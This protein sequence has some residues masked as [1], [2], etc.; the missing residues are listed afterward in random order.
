MKPITI[1]GGGLAGLTL[2]ILLRRENVPVAAIEAGKYPR[3]RV[4]GEFISGRGL[5]IFRGL[6]L[7][8]GKGIEASTCSFHLKNR[9]PVKLKLDPSALCISR[10]ELDALL[11]EEFER[12]G[13]ILKLGERANF[14]ADR[15]GVVRA[16]G[17][18]RS[19]NA[20]GHL[21][22]LK[23]HAI[24]AGL[25]SDL[26][27]H[28]GAGNYVGVC[29]LG[30]QRANVCGLFYSREPMRSLNE[31]WKTILASS[32]WSS[33]VESVT[34]DEAS[35]SS[36][37]GLT[38]SRHAPESRF[39]IGDAAAMIPPLTGNGMSMAFESAALA[40][41]WLLEFSAGR[42]SWTKCL[43]GHTAAWRKAF[44][45]RLRWAGFV[46]PVLFS[47]AGQEFL[48][49]CTRLFPTLPTFFFARTR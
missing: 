9:R 5:G 24:G 22:G 2:G 29:K 46:Q 26:E 33:A 28:F 44:S 20:A 35:F 34:W 41:K 13:G 6:G 8:G 11:A 32:I 16:T 42:I 43:Q 27:L 15:E 7:E 12:V 49:I 30:D 19:E 18:R 4:C 40:R 17:R 38:L 39:S 3:H 36:V 10:F 1:I 25:S 14:D 21:F 47:G 23:A 37:A 48:L 31:K 45:S